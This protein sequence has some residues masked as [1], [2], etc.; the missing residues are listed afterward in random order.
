MDLDD[1]KHLGRTVHLFFG[2][3]LGSVEKLKEGKRE[4]GRVERTPS[5]TNPRTSPI[6]GHYHFPLSIGT[7]VGSGGGE[8]L[9]A[10]AAVGQLALWR[11]RDEDLGDEA[12]RRWLPVAKQ[13]RCGAVCAILDVG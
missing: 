10:A 11:R 3:V 1:E 12:K 7:G 13:R 2:F 6:N 8:K 4:R 5:T 9:T